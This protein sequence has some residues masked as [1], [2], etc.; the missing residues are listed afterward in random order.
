MFD[1]ETHYTYLEIIENKEI[2]F[3]V[4]FFMLGA[5]FR[6]STNKFI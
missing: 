5:M 2:V 6:E 3:F 4:V 1:I